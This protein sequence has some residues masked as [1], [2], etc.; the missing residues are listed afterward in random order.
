[1]KARQNAELELA[2]TQLQVTHLAI[3]PESFYV[4]DIKTWKKGIFGKNFWQIF[5]RK[6]TPV[7]I[8]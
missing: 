6:Y 3:A 5:S 8:A 2:D 1:M 7:L 4:H